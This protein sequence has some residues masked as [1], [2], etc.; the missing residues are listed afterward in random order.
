MSVLSVKL[1][2]LFLSQR[3]F[4]FWFACRH[5]PTS[6]QSAPQA[7]GPFF[8]FVLNFSTNHKKTHSAHSETHECPR[9]KYLSCCG[10]GGIQF[11]CKPLNE[12]EPE[13][14]CVSYVTGLG[15]MSERK[16]V[17]QHKWSIVVSQRAA[18]LFCF[19]PHLFPLPSLNDAGMDRMKWGALM[20]GMIKWRKVHR[21]EH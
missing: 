18:D 15:R 5:S 13:C 1:F 19:K 21:G 2:E 8:F 17:P 10:S 12:L 3:R 6:F 9:A 4:K 11:P 14:Y 16:K 20:T 7:V